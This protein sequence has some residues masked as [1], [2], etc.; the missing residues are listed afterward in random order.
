MYIR[1]QISTGTI[2]KLKEREN[3]KYIKHMYSRHK[4][5]N[6]LVIV[7]DSKDEESMKQ[8]VEKIKKTIRRENRLLDGG[9]SFE[10]NCNI[11]KF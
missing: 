5:E 3:P 4:K 10:I 1:K 9:V 8:L 2:E 7:V 11:R 6:H